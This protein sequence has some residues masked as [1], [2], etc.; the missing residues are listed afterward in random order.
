MRS[1]AL[2]SNLVD[3]ARSDGRLSWLATV[4]DSVRA[5]AQ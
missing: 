2:P 4:P 1:L 3:S 5:V